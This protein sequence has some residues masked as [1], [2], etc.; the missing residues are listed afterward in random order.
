MHQTYRESSFVFKADFFLKKIGGGDIN[1]RLP[2]N[3]YKTWLD[4]FVLSIIKW[5]M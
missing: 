2:T 4:F 1:G 5:N 3:K